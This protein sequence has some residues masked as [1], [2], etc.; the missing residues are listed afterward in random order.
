M[1]CGLPLVSTDCPSGP[2]EILRDGG[3]GKLVPVGDVPEM[4]RAIRETLASGGR[5]FPGQEWKRVEIDV[6]AYS[7]EKLL[8]GG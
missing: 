1:A 6:A 7:Y 4:A 3:S 8:I 5:V 2:R